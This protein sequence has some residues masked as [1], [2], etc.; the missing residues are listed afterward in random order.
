VNEWREADLDVDY[1]VHEV[2]V[3]TAV[4]SDD[5]LDLWRREGAM[6]ADEAARRVHEALCAATAPDGSLVGVSTAYL[7]R[8]V[9]LGLDLWY[10]RVFVA[11]AHRLSTVAALLGFRS[12]GLL[13][14]RWTAG[15]DRRGVGV[16]IEVENEGMR[17]AL[18]GAVWQPND[19]H[20]IGINQR[21][22]HVRV[23]YFP[24]AVAPLPPS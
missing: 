19:V 2:G 17:R 14:D 15:A 5:V 10:Y 11:E 16:V 23:T 9:Q 20:F 1:T 12:H 21:G 6:P 7:K 3:S 13:L 22:D 8:N 4:G 18:T 24:G